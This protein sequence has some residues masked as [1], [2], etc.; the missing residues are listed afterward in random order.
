VP[1][2]WM[3]LPLMGPFAGR[4]AMGMTA[5]PHLQG[6]AATAAS[7]GRQRSAA[8]AAGSGGSVGAA[9]GS[10]PG[11]TSSGQNRISESWSGCHAERTEHVVSARSPP[12]Q[13]QVAH[14]W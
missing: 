5:H 13:C 1:A 8:A 14:F 9:G 11:P 12:G 6:P 3:P 4:P 10:G 7:P 2:Q